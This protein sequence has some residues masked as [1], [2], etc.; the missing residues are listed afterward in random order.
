MKKSKIV[1][2]KASCHEDSELN[3]QFELFVYEISRATENLFGF[4]TLISWNLC[5]AV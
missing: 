2:L 3:R 4:L 1:N 5:A